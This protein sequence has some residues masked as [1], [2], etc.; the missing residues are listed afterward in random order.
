MRSDQTIAA[1]TFDRT[2]VL[3]LAKG[4]GDDA[5]QIGESATGTIDMPV[6][7]DGKENDFTLTVASGGDT[8]RYTLHIERADS[9]YAS[10]LQWRSATSGDPNTNPV[11]RDLSCGNHAITLWDGEQERTFDKGVG[12]HAVSDITYDVSSLGAVRFEAYAGVDRELQEVDQSHAEVEFSV[13]VDGTV[14]YTSPAMR[15][16]TAMEA[17]SVD[18]PENATTVTLHVGNRGD[19]WGDHADWADAR[20]IGAPLPTVPDV[21]SVTI[22]GEGVTDD[23]TLTMTPGQ[24]VRLSATVLPDTI[25]DRSV[26]WSIDGTGADDVAS[27]DDDGTLTA[28]AAGTVRV[29]AV[30]N[31][32]TGVSDTITLTVR[33][34][35]PDPVPG[36]KSALQAAVDDASSLREADY[37]AASWKPFA[38]A[39][40]DARTVLADDAAD[41]DDVSAALTALRD[42]RNGLK[43][44]VANDDRRHP[45]D[46][47]KPTISN[48]GATVT[49]A[50]I[51]TF[52]V[53]VSG[54]LMMTLRRKGRHGRP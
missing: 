11:R 32:D 6:S 48:T 21:S 10:D 19:N 25:K 29:Q 8:A 30:A 17:V 54:A 42:A 22:T 18:I 1:A 7:L 23:G 3:T 45:Q 13:S 5:E 51:M 2:A 40:A 4:A 53:G 27:I 31:A 9:V 24:H 39:L 52:L 44:P 49:G 34:A 15:Y 36:D 43:T 20:F 12:T 28:L 35:D 41:A 46:N 16:D 47:G 37:T 14:A 26:T 50:V 38:Q 33:D